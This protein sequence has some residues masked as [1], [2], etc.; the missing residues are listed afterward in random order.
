VSGVAIGVDLGGSGCRVCLLDENGTRLA[1]DK[2]D[3]QPEL[4]AEALI[5]NIAQLIARVRG[6]ATPIGLGVG[7][8]GVLDQDGGVGHG[9]TN[10]PMVAGL[11]LG[12]QLERASN[13]PV[14]LDND[15]R[16]AMLGEALHGAAR[17][18]RD[19]L[20]ITLGTGIGGG[21]LLDGR[22]RRG[23]HR[24]AGE[25]G[26]TQVA[27]RSASGPIDWVALEDIASPGGLWRTRQLEL[28]SLASDAASGHPD[29][30][31]TLE[32]VYR[33]I[34]IAIANA[35]VLIDLELVLL[36]G[37]MTR[38]G[39]GLF[40]GVRRMF[41]RYCPSD[42][43]GDLRIEP[44]GLGEWAGAVGAAC[45]WLEDRPRAISAES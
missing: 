41:K 39:E 28:A 1:E 17:G 4:P 36:A 22:V 29:A 40:D 31:R 43:S 42:L 14:R 30:A 10:L 20:T 21:L 37:G 2:S 5:D 23:P 16:A 19:A 27:E 11:P 24:A 18:V 3:H 34:G 15:A 38:M 7:V 26:L 44:A 32:E 45:L 12:R 33:S 35:H 6:S 25:I 8:A 9:M 13:L